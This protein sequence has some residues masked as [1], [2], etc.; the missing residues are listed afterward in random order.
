V[1]GS[2]LWLV[3]RIASKS[4]VPWDALLLFGIL[5]VGTWVGTISRGAIYLG[6]TRLYIP[7]A[8]YAYPAIIPTVTLLAAGWLEWL[9]LRKPWTAW[10]EPARRWVPVVWLLVLG[11]LDAYAIASIL[12]YYGLG[13]Q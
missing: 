13:W 3:R 4:A 5:L 9:S 11:L 10:K 7:V 1:L 12:A 2:I 6:I 8:R